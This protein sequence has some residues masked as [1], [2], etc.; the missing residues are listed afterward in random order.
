M[1][2]RLCGERGNC[3]N[4]AG[5]YWC[6]CNEGYTNYGNN[7]TKCTSR[8]KCCRLLSLNRVLCVCFWGC[9]CGCR[10]GA[11]LLPSVDSVTLSQLRV[12]RRLLG[13]SWWH[14][15]RSPA[16][17][18]NLKVSLCFFSFI[19]NWT[20]AHSVWTRVLHRWDC[21]AEKPRNS[22]CIKCYYYKTSF[23]N[24]FFCA[25]VALMLFIFLD[26]SLPHSLKCTPSISHAMAIIRALCLIFFLSNRK[27]AYLALCLQASAK[28]LHSDTLFTLKLCQ[29][30]LEAN[31]FLGCCLGGWE[32]G[33][34]GMV[35]FDKGLTALCD[36]TKGPCK[37]NTCVLDQW[38]S[39]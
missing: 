21:S 12:T 3:S 2:R 37:K 18:I 16:Q 32:E 23:I 31:N 22:I 27:T 17:P 29:M 1:E 30:N 26:Q 9:V 10:C 15:Q 39:E 5:S 36:I 8:C 33:S 35:L 25:S 24:Q 34:G 19:Q 38:L 13:G 7:A 4:V 28:I 14:F 20:A 6:K 11:V